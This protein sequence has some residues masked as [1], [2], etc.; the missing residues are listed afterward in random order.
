VKAELRG[1]CAESGATASLALGE[2]IAEAL[3]RTLPQVVAP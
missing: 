2:E 3:T 1:K